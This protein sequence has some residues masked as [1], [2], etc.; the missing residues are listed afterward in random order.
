MGES[1]E[2]LLLWEKYWSGCSVFGTRSYGM[3]S[4]DHGR[5][6]GSTS[7]SETKVWKPPM[8][9]EGTIITLDLLILLEPF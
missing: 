6:G 9:R 4:S 2:V 1:S 5:S 8:K 3:M 7:A